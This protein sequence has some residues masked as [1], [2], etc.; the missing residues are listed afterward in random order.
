MNLHELIVKH[1]DPK[2]TLATKCSCGAK[3]EPEPFESDGTMG[4]RYSAEMRATWHAKHL[5]EV[6]EGSFDVILKPPGPTLLGR[7]GGR[8]M[9]DWNIFYNLWPRDPR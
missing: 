2:R 7:R 5:A 4:S 8:I 6:I 1:Y 3:V 9:T